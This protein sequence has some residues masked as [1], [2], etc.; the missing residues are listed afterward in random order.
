MRDDIR[1][2]NSEVLEAIRRLPKEVYDAR[3]FRLIRALNLSNRKVVLPREEWTKLEEV[4]PPPL[5]MLY[6]NSLSVISILAR[7][8]YDA[9]GNKNTTKVKGSNG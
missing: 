4:R 5:L 3:N 9:L 7:R 8:C 2:E 1:E 6:F